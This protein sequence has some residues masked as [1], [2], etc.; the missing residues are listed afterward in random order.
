MWDVGSWVPATGEH[1][2]GEVG[3][4]FGGR[5]ERGGRLRPSHR[6]NQGN[7]NELFFIRQVG[8]EDGQPD[9]VIGTQ[10]D[11]IEPIGYVNF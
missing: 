8:E 11:A 5:A 10:A 6:E 9:G 7:S 3:G 1:A 4:R 2:V